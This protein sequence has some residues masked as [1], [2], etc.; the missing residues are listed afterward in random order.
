MEGEF[1][2]LLEESFNRLKNEVITGTVVKVTDREAFI[3]FGW[4]SEGVVPI[5]ELGYKPQIGEK[6]DVCVVE[7]ETEEGYA[8]LSVNCARSLKEWQQLADEIEKKGIVRGRIRQRVRGGY[9]VQIEEGITV[10]LPMS[11][12][13]IMPVTKPD[14]WLDREIEAKVLSVDRK[15]KSIVISRRKLLEEERAK[16]RKETIKKLKEGDIVEG[17]VKNIVD[18]GIFVDVDGVDGLVHKTDISWSGLKTPF[19][20]A[21]IGDRIKVKIKKIEHDKERLVLSLKDVKEDPWEKIEELFKPGME[22]E[23]TVAK[24]DKKGYWIELPGDVA[25]YIPAT[26][27]PKGVKLKYHHRY[28][29]IVDTIDK[30]KRRVVLKWQENPQK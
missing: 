19:D 27:L 17:T 25:G 16:K 13:D 6:I 4:K 18:F 14:D 28:K 29:F 3:D 5:K 15:R 9:K 23:G 22:V 12:V 20:V 10:F 2:K 1:A 24:E 30:E 21:K 26:A 8:L 11:Q 7:P